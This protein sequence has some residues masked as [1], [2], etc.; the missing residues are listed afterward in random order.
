MKFARVAST[1]PRL[2]ATMTR[3]SSVMRRTFSTIVRSRSSPWGPPRDW[4]KF[5]LMPLTSCS[6]SRASRVIWS[7]LTGASPC[8]TEP[9][10]R[11]DAP[12]GPGVSSTYFSPS[13]PRF[14]IAAEAPCRRSTSGSMS[15]STIAFPVALSIRIFAT[16][17][18]RTPATRT[19]DLASSP[20]TS[21]N[22][23]EIRCALPRPR[24][25]S[26]IRQTRRPARTKTITK[27]APTFAAALMDP[28]N[29]FSPLPP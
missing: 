6:M 27:N 26:S 15:T 25:S 11:A 28:P 7:K 24:R 14:A 13:S 20:A 1:L 19:V 3:R 2:D 23:I 5:E 22:S 10:G 9:S 4:F 16:F 18:T 12:T 8:R 17:P 21:L 29:A